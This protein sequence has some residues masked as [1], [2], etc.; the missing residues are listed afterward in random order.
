MSGNGIDWSQRI[1]LAIKHIEENLEENLRLQDVADIACCSKYHFHRLFYGFVGTTFAEYVRRRRLTLAAKDL[2]RGKSKVID[3]AAKYNYESHNAFTR[4]FRK[5]HGF[6]PS[7]I[8]SYQSKLAS[9]SRASFPN[10]INCGVKMQYQIVNRQSFDVLGKSKNFRFDDFVKNGP[11]F[12]KEY[13]ASDAYQR[14]Y[15]ITEGRP[16]EVSEAALLSVYFPTDG[17]VGDEFTDVLG[18]EAGRDLSLTGHTRHTVP[19]ATY[20]D[21]YC[22]YKTSMKTNR[23]IYGE[24]FPS[25]NY[26][27]DGDKPD[28][29]SYFPIAFRPMGEMIVRWSIPVLFSEEL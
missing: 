7:E 24:W 5:V 29:V 3:I 8:R 10:L 11:K 13:V 18:V 17:Q 19:A 2:L 9:Y 25:T 27:R 16:G 23:Y 1:H 21:F 20:A 22:T 4:A 15:R 14:L 28:L 6:N 12:W 26:E